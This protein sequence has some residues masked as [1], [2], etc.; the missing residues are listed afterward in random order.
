VLEKMKNS[1]ADTYY[2]ETLDPN[3]V[4]AARQLG[5]LTGHTVISE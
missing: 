3:A 4:K 5:M 2:I 1:G